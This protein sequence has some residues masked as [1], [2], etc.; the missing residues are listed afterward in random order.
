MDRA[1]FPQRIAVELTNK[2]NLACT[3]CHRVEI[4]MKLGNMSTDLYKK[5]ID[6][7]SERTPVAM[8]PFFRGESLLHPKFIDFIRYAKEKGIAPIQMTSN[9]FLLD[10]KMSYEII[11][12]GI[13]FISFSMDTLDEEKYNTSRV[14]GDLKR[15]MNNVIRFTEI[16]EEYKK[17]GEK[18]PEIQVSSVDTDDYRDGQEEFISFW[19][20][21][22]DFV[23]IYEEH[24]IDGRFRNREHIKEADTI[25]KRLPCRRL[26]TDMVINWDGSISLCCYDWAETHNLGNVQNDSIM[27][28]WNADEMQKLRKMHENN[29]IT[30]DYLC[31]QC[32]YWKA[33]YLDEK[34]L[35]K[36]IEGKH[37]L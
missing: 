28:I 7:M 37:G 26:Y 34:V 31:Y 20:E 33:D 10:E 16:C 3:F 1:S 14:H 11:E 36:K 21:H 6:E 30:S 32:E 5:I 35:G 17:K 13:D 22:A 4:D 29:C 24:D 25:I 8:V 23:R 2:C 12:S 18:V 9:G 27:K 19:R 15:S